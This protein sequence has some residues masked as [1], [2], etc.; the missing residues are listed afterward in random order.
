MLIAVVMTLIFVFLAFTVDTEY[1]WT[2][3]CE[4]QSAANEAAAASAAGLASGTEAAMRAAG[5][6]IADKKA[7]GVPVDFGRNIEVGEWDANLQSFT[8]NSKNA[9]AVRVTARVKTERLVFAPVFGCRG[10]A[11]QA[12]AIGVRNAAGKVIVIDD[13]DR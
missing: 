1:L 7:G 8:L 11:L 5:A 4:L 9:N 13:F 6:S 3:K 2:I 12:Q 10:A